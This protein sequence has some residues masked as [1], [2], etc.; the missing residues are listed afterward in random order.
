[1]ADIPTPI[2]RD[3]LVW[4]SSSYAEGGSALIR[5]VPAADGTFA[6]KELKYYEKSKG[7]INNHHGG[8]VL[9]GDYVYF[10]NDQNEGQPVCVE[11]KTGE[12]KWGPDK[13][14]AGGQKSSAY[15]YADGLFYVR[16]QN[17][18]MTLLDLS[19][20]GLKVVSS[21]KPADASKQSAWAHPV[22]ANGRLYLAT[23]AR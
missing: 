1:M 22:V 23:R 12:I 13:P 18:V 8:M 17:H 15:L 9:V 7:G 3:D 5:L 4:C 19:P 2:V 10:G 14:P 21:F 11:F 6:V 16:F 20:E